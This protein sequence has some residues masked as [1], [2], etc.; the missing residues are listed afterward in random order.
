MYDKFERP[1]DKT[2]KSLFGIRREKAPPSKELLEELRDVAKKNKT[3][4]N[5]METK[6]DIVINLLKEGKISNNQLRILLNDINDIKETYYVVERDNRY[7]DGV[8]TIY[9]DDNLYEVQIS[10]TK[11]LLECDRY[12]T[13]EE[14]KEIADKYFCNVR[15]VIVK[16]EEWS[17]VK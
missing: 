17:D 6:S 2:M 10:T 8:R 9:V 16:V 5:K 11:S 1:S 13:R 3:G 15:K 14:A 4:N 12:S 7:V